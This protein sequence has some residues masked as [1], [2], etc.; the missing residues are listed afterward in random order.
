M[1]S[2]DAVFNQVS[3]CHQ[4]VS[5]LERFKSRDHWEEFSDAVHKRQVFRGDCDDFA[6]TILAYGIKYGG[7][8][9]GLCRVARVATELCPENSDF[10][11]AVAVY[12]GIVL[13]NRMPRPVRMGYLTQYR[14]YD[15]AAIPITK[16][17][18]YDESR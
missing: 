17:Q 10:D 12:D 5:D 7:W 11:H 6:L 8:D 1:Q 9:R 4:W 16:W 14:F 15:Y 18:R 13:D 2:V 3:D